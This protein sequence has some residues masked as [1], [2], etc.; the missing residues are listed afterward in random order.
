[1]KITRRQIGLG[2]IQQMQHVCPDCRGSGE[3]INERDKCPLCKGNKVSQEKKV[4]EVHVE[5]G[6]QQGQKIV[7]EG[8]ADEAPDTITGDIVFVLQVKDHPKFRREQDDLYIDHNLSLTEALCG[9]QFAV[10]H[11]DGRQLLIKSNPGEVIKPGQYKAL[12]DEGMPQH[13]RPFMKGRLYIQFN[14]DFPDSGFLSPDQ[15]QLLEKVLPQKSSKHVSD[16]ELDDCEETTLH[17]VNFKEE[18]RRKQQQQ[19]REAYDEDD[20][21]PSGQR[22]QCAQQ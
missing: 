21:E 18:M 22:V 8:Q 4:L 17:D 6:M 1:M 19:Y 7:F 11:L 5:K 3:V 9:F 2:M 12:N 14:V 13:N 16:M 20:D 10:K 15:C